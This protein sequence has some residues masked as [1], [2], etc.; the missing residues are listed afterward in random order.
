MQGQCAESLETS[1]RFDLGDRVEDL[2]QS[3]SCSW[4]RASVPCVW[5]QEGKVKGW[6]LRHLQGTVSMSRMR[7]LPAV[8]IGKE[9]P[10]A[11]QTTGGISGK[12]NPPPKLQKPAAPQQAL[13]LHSC[14]LGK[15]QT[16]LS[17]ARIHPMRNT[18]NKH[19][20]KGNTR[21]YTQLGLSSPVKKRRARRFSL[22]A[23]CVCSHVTVLAPRLAC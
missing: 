12:R 3:G 13:Q 18:G 21:L 5:E 9:R 20:S 17:S 19:R 10:G 6:I 2:L 8:H 11:K 16:A 22:Q 1:L 4:Q 7:Q 15:G 23:L 14:R